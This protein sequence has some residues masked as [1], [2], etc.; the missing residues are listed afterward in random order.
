M[1]EFAEAGLV[2][3]IGLSNYELEDVERCHRNGRVDA[4]QVGLT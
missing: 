2:R 1:A 4:V 3:A